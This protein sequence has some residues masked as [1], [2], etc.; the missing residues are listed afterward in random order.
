MTPRDQKMFTTIG[1]YETTLIRAG[2]RRVTD[3]EADALGVRFTGNRDGIWFPRIDPWSGD[4]VGG[5]LRRDRPEVEDGKLK[6]KY[7]STYGDRVHLYLSATTA[8]ALADVKVPVVFV[9]AE[10]SA[11]MLAGLEDVSLCPIG[12]GGCYGWKGTIGKTANADGARVDEKGPCSDF[13]HIAWQGRDVVIFFDSN[14]TTNM[15]VLAAERAVS[16]E[17]T[18]RGARVR[19][20]RVPAEWIAQCPGINGPD[21]YFAADSHGG[22]AR[23]LAAIATAQP[24]RVACESVADHLQ[25]AGLDTLTDVVPADLEVRLRRLADTLRGVDALRRQLVRDAAI[26]ALKGAKVPGAAGLIDAALQATTTETTQDVTLL[27]D[28]AP[29]PSSVDGADLLDALADAVR[30]YVVLPTRDAADAVALWI[31]MAW[32]ESAV[33]ILAILSFVSPTPRCGKSTAV[34]VVGALA[35]RALLVSGITPAALF[36]SVEVWHPTLLID[37]A[38]TV[39]P[40]NEDLRGVLNAGHTRHAAVVI[41]CV[42]DDQTPTRFSVW[43]PKVLALIGRPPTTV[44]DRSI[45]IEL[46]RKTPAD[47]VT[48]LRLD[49]I[50]D[51]LALLRQQCR[52]WVDDHAEHLRDADPALP[53]AL[54]DRAMDNWRG[55]VAIADL[56]GG[57]WPARARAAALVVSGAED[58]GDV[59]IGVLLLA[60]IA[61]VWTKNAEWM[62]SAVLLERLHGVE[63]RPWRAMGRGDKPLTG[64]KL[65][66]LLRPFS[67]ENRKVRDG[68]RTVNA[69]LWSQVSEAVTRYTPPTKAEQRNTST[70]SRGKLDSK[71]EQP[72]EPCSALELQNDQRRVGVFRRS[73][74]RTGPSTTRVSDDDLDDEDGGHDALAV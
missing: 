50:G 48:R 39:L 65:A 68:E 72:P 26:A 63:D 43:C 6:N 10:K 53:A 44:L 5:R 11:L 25:A 18:R 8:D 19:L 9:E 1:V 47:T 23:V 3:D 66:R 52:R 33:S 69:Y 31:L 62:A 46:R 55:M 74:L 12:T 30:R 34:A 17:L 7:L 71:A 15:K 32:A 49:K 29:W 37:E 28:D 70:E 36:R 56:A 61:D 27:A 54:H 21:D 14:V 42:G 38:D 45:L 73:A 20:A 67:I 41:R 60:D 51:E 40:G 35:P 64:A 4:V 2:V 59:P 58:D 22:A 24:A 13:D 57:A 16:D